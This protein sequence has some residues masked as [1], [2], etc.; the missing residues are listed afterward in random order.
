[1][2]I[3]KVR[4]ANIP[5]ERLYLNKDWYLGSE[6]IEIYILG[7]LIYQIQKSKQSAMQTLLSSFFLLL[8]ELLQRQ[9][10]PWFNSSQHMVPKNLKGV[11]EVKNHFHKRVEITL[12]SFFSVL[13]FAFCY[14]SNCRYKYCCL[15]TSQSSGTKLYW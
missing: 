14:K 12:F 1:M 3:P 4:I 9:C 15:I 11:C 8:K 5:L 7:K 2:L 10:K 6:S 13:R